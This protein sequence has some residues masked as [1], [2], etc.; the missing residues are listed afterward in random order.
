MLQLVF[1]FISRRYYRILVTRPIP[2]D[3][4]QRIWALYLRS[5]KPLS[6]G[7]IAKL[8]GVSK[9]AVST[10]INEAKTQDPN[11]ALMRALVLNVG[12]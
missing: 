11:Y 4:K 7:V 1:G 10:I 3:I 9:T 8:V 2:E 5:K 6:L 12:K